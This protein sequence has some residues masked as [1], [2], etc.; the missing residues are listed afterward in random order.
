M[1][2]LPFLASGPGDNSEGDLVRVIFRTLK[3]LRDL[4]DIRPTIFEC[5]PNETTQGPVFCPADFSPGYMSDV[6]MPT[7]MIVM[8]Q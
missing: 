8:P 6:R 2:H 5:F 4:F 7:S 3:H 1:A